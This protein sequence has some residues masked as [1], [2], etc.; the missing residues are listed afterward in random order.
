MSLELKLLE[1]NATNAAKCIASTY[2]LPT[3][4]KV[5]EWSVEYPYLFGENVAGITIGGMI[6]SSGITMCAGSLALAIAERQDLTPY[7]A[8]AAVGGVL[9]NIASGVSE[10]KKILGKRRAR[11]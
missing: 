5:S 4:L 6:S 11:E 7:I 10:Y 3:V 2:I 1:K 9:T 8:L